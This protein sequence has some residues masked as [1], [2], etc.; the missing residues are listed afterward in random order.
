MAVTDATMTNTT[1]ANFIPT[2]WSDDVIDA[3]EFSSVLQKR[4]NTEWKSELKVGNTLNVPYTSN[5]QTQSKSQGV[6]NTINFEAPT[7]GRQQVTVSTWEYAAFM[8]EGITQVQAN[9]DLRQRYTRKIGYALSRGRET[10][11]ANLIQNL[12]TNVVGTL[13]VEMTSDDYIQALRLLGEAG[14]L[15]ES[16]DPGEEYTL[17][18]SWAAYAALL[19]VEQFIN[20]DYAGDKASEAIRR[21]HVGEILGFPVYRSNLLRS[22]AGGQHDCAAFRKEAFALIVQEEVPVQSQYLIRNLSDGIVGWNVYGAARVLFPVETPGT[23][24]SAT[25]QDNRAVYVKTV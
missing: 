4:V 10:T 1:H 8:V 2:I 20:R 21:A 11:L 9:Q 23:Y 15:E 25:T 5:L 6:S 3:V 18:L 16:P 12:T 19:K 24:S 7:E 22:P 17:A 13:G 14:V